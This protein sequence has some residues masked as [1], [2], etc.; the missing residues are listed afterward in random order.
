MT[1]AHEQLKAA[2]GHVR[3]CEK[4]LYQGSEPTS[5]LAVIHGEDGQLAQTSDYK[6]RH[7]KA[8]RALSLILGYSEPYRDNQRK[9]I[10]RPASAAIPA[11]VLW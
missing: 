9:A 7:A 3:R 1:F 6:W 4:P 5:W 11:F 8:C 10:N 2:C